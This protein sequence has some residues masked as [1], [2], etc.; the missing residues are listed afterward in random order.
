MITAL[1]FEATVPPLR[2]QL[3][4]AAMRLTRDPEQADDLVQ[5]TMVRA[6]RY[7]HTFQQGTNVKA[8]MFTILRN[9]FISGYHRAGRRQD[10]ENDV[11][12]QMHSLGPALAIVSTEPEPDAEEA[13]AVERTR[14]R[15]REALD[16]LPVDYRQAV[17]LA[18][19]EG[20]SYKE[21]A[22]A[23]ECPIGTVM[24]RLYRGRKILHG[25]LHEHATEIGIVRDGDDEAGERPT[26]RKTRAGIP[27]DLVRLRSA[28]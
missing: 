4:G 21:I 25:L 15:I 16:S 18:D 24:S 19:I 27:I 14:S 11:T 26:T 7:W 5:D 10:F 9:T 13:I 8:W 3:R 20:L 17:T 6:F 1:D 12:A 22:D 28:S 2:S 23:M